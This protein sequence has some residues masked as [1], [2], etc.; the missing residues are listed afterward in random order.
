M[1]INYSIK[2]VRKDI[3]NRRRRLKEKFK[4]LLQDL[5]KNTKNSNNYAN[6]LSM[7]SQNIISRS[8]YKRHK[9][10]GIYPVHQI[11]LGVGVEVLM[12]GIIVLENP[13]IFRD[14]STM[15][16]EALKKQI[17]R[18]LMK[19]SLKKSQINLILCGLEIIQFKRNWYAHGCYGG[20]DNFK[21]NFI[22]L[23]MLELL[24]ATYFPKRKPI[25]K[26][27]KQFK[28]IYKY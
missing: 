1:K 15:K 8:L 28:E 26:K 21:D 11:I 25:I 19:S 12:K 14:N 9:D 10:N 5:N 24:F 13:R 2:T 18:I 7:I 23:S 4:N 20:H 22:V 27:I 16:F 3:S 17:L 6:T